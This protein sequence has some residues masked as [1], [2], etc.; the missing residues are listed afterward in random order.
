MIRAEH[1]LVWLGLAVVAGASP[2]H[3][4]EQKHVVDLAEL[5]ASVA[6]RAEIDDGNRETVMRVLRHPEVLRVASET[7]VD[8]R[9]AED[10]VAT[11]EGP[12]LERLA[13]Q[14]SEVEKALVGGDNITIGSTTLIIILLVV[15]IL[16]VA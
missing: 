13:R 11:L 10:A 4:Q 2:V 16:L 6:S 7:G 3:G 14:A 5:R 15:I 8:L 1:L 9:S 12:E